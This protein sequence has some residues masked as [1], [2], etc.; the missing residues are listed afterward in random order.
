ML[1]ELITSNQSNIILYPKSGG[2]MMLNSCYL[3]VST[4]TGVLG[5][6]DSSII[7]EAIWIT[8]KKN[9][10]IGRHEPN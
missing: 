10:F 2:T 8:L 3:L 7:E 9:E 6:I 1:R 4:A 5:V